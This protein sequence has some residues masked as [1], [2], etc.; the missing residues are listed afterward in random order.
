MHND[1]PR[2]LTARSH[3]PFSHSTFAFAQCT[4]YYPKFN[5]ATEREFTRDKKGGKKLTQANHIQVYN[6]LFTYNCRSLRQKTS[7][8]R[9][10][11][12]LHR[13]ACIE[14]RS[15]QSLAKGGERLSHNTKHAPRFIFHV[16]H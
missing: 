10:L 16:S 15:N 14:S 1:P 5:L 3:Q 2:A 4:V 9:P 8:N 12:D 7:Q 6:T 13:S 11:T